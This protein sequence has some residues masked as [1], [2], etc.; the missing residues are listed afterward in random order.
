MIGLEEELLPHARTLQPQATD[1]TDLD[2]AT[3][4]SEERRLCYVGITRAQ[5]KLYL[6]RACTRVS[7]GRSIPRTPSRFL[8]EIPDE[9]LEV[10]DLGEEARQRV[11][12]D[13]VR[14]FFANF[15]FDD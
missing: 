9:L 7:R 1:V 10:R 4:I 11:P 15:A 8:L 12:K 14:D 2:H 13:E 5:R 3:D 6:T